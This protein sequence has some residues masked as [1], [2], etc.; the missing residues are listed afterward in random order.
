MSQQSHTTPAPI[1][2]RAVE[3]AD[4]DFLY[5]AENDSSAWSVASTTAPMSRLMLQE[6]IEQYSADLYRDK[7]LRL[8]AQESATG[9]VI[10]IVDLYDY[11]P[12]NS[13]AAVGIYIAPQL[14]SQ[15]YGKQALDALCSYAQEFVGIHTLY[16]FIAQY[17]IASRHIFA[18]CL[19]V[20]TATLPQWIKTPQ[21][22]TSAI[23]VQRIR[24]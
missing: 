15:G 14:R 23:I 5:L 18:H 4:L 2:L 24:E 7:Q 12:R 16:A 22:Y 10:G 9:K 3:P 13:R 21:G 8:I 1:T 19:F 20:E 17:N 6:Y 11:D